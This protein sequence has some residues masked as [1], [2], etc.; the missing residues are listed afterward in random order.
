MIR[1]KLLPSSLK[2]S[3]PG[4]IMT[5]CLS[6]QKEHLAA[7]HRFTTKFAEGKLNYLG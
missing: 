4:E 1:T 3:S 2:L 6:Q 7:P 5:S